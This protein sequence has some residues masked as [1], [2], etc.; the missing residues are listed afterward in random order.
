[1]WLK[2]FKIL[3]V[4]LLVFLLSTSWLVVPYLVCYHVVMKCNTTYLCNHMS[5]ALWIWSQLWENWDCK[6]ITLKYLD[7]GIYFY[8]A[9][10]IIIIYVCYWIL[11]NLFRIYETTLWLISYQFSITIAGKFLYNRFITNWSICTHL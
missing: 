4:V 6:R 7:H 9:F 11:F 8:L 3:Q 1:M 2:F 10:R 5:N